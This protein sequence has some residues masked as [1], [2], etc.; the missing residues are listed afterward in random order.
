MK[1]ILT[2][3]ASLRLQPVLRQV[4]RA[5]CTD[6]IPPT[7]D[8]RGVVLEPSSWQHLKQQVA[9]NTVD[10]LGTLGRTSVEIEV[11]RT[12]RRQVRTYCHLCAPCRLP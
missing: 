11:Y 1:C 2:Q 9:E 10:S 3:A 12:F 4:I 6:V 7:G 8:M 5:V